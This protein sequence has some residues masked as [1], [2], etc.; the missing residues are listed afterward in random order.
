MKGLKN[1]EKSG[2]YLVREG[3]LITIVEMVRAVIQ[4]EKETSGDLRLRAG[5]TSQKK[6]Q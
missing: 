2:P 6:A 5:G 3:V 4:S 1:V